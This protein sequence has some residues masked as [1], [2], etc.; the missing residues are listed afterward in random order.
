MGNWKSGQYTIK[1]AYHLIKKG[2]EYNSREG[3]NNNWIEALW[4]AI[5]KIK[6]P[7]KVQ[8]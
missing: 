4:K 3:S 1:S 7:Q 6:V 5:W 2:L 8:V